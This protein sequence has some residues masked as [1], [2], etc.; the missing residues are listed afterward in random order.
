MTNILEF[1]TSKNYLNA[2]GVEKP[3]PIKLN[4]PEWYKNLNHSMTDRTI[5]GCMPFLDALSAGYLLRCPQDLFFNYGLQ[6]K[7][8]EPDVAYKN[9][10]QEQPIIV[11]EG[12][13]L[14][15]D[16]PESHAAR[17]YPDPI[18]QKQQGTRPVL[19][20]ANPWIIKT[21]P[22][23]SCLF[24]S[25]LNN[26]HYPWKIISGIVD[27]DAFHKEINFPFSVDTEKIENE[28]KTFVIE[29][30]TP[31]VQVI[32]FKRENWKM[33]IKT[34]VPGDRSG[35]FYPLKLVHIYKSMFW[36]KK[37]WK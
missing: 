20:I 37:S 18:V 23:Y 6:T 22:G 35:I 19:K 29:K 26:H 10:L 25:P 11:S 16:T 13:N 4:I 33:R 21:P 30:G 5:K 1:I 14:N 36:T 31:Y 27:T 7:K 32:P 8:G 3:Q 28:D 9:S 17:Q 12:T 2:P 15:T 34:R 24:T